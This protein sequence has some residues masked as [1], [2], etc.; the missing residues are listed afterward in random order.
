MQVT[1]NYFWMQNAAQQ[2]KQTH[3]NP[4]LKQAQNAIAHQNEKRVSD[5]DAKEME[6]K[7]RQNTEEAKIDPKD[8]AYRQAMEELMFCEQELYR[9]LGWEKAELT[10]LLHKKDLFTGVLNGTIDYEKACHSI[11][12]NPVDCE[13]FEFIDFHSYLEANGY[14]KKE[15]NHSTLNSLVEMQDENGF[16]QLMFEDQVPLYE[17]W[18]EDKQAHQMEKLKEYARDQLP[19]IQ[20]RIEGAPK[21]INMIYMA[22]SFKRVEIMLKYSDFLDDEDLESYMGSVSEV[23]DLADKMRSA[24]PADGEKVLELLN[25]I[26]GKQQQIVL[27]L[28]GTANDVFT[29]ISGDL[30]PPTFRIMDINA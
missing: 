22:Y 23:S 12:I 7:V 11:Y 28:G 14:Q 27:N 25:Q 20:E 29:G 10:N 30:T 3:V 16:S 9:N 24:D 8:R 15:L 6:A 21:R 19:K 26:L 2:N 5:A 17:Q 1:G 13:N 18:K 4:L